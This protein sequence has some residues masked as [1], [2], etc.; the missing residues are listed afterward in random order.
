MVAERFR[1]HSIL[2]FCVLAACATDRADHAANNKD[3]VDSDTAPEDD[4]GSIAIK[5]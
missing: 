2:L 1:R 4:D 5:G 3:A